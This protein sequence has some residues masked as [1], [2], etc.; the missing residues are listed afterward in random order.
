VKGWVGIRADLSTVTKRKVPFLAGKTQIIFRCYQT[1][2]RNGDGKKMWRGWDK[3][4]GEW[5]ERDDGMKCIIVPMNGD[6]G[7]F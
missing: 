2:E 5:R 3:N 4:K 1:A 7:L 6:E